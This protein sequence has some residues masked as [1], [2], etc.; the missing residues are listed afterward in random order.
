[1]AAVGYCGDAALLDLVNAA[2]EVKQQALPFLRINF[3]GSIGMLLFFMVSAA[4]RAAGDARTPLRLGLTM[5][6]LNV[7]LNVLL[8]RGFGPI[9]ALGHGRLGAGNVHRLRRRQPVRAVAPVPGRLR[10]SFFASHG[11][12]AR[13]GDYPGALP[14]WPAHRRPGHRDE[15]RR[16]A[17]AAVHGIARAE[18]GRAGGVRDRLHR[19][20]FDDHVDVGGL[21]GCGG[22]DRRPESGRRPPRAG[23]SGVYHAARIGISVAAVV[24]LMFVAFPH[25]LLGIFGATEPDV[26]TIGE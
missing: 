25:A 17:D 2:P 11:L 9:P 16:R 19:A 26:A 4:M 24:G 14:L 8:I 1:M 20:V 5:T 12:A 10:D 23:H 3:I 21:D 18:R 6:V 22:D 15:H 7:M 13:L